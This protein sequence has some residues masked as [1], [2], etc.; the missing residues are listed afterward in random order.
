MAMALLLAGCDAKDAA[1]MW[2][3]AADELRGAPSA[4]ALQ[5]SAH[6][7]DGGVAFDYPTVLRERVD[8]DDDGD[9]SWNFEYGMYTLEV[10]HSRGEMAAADYLGALGELFAGGERLDA[11]PLAQGEPRELC[12]A[13]RTPARV[14]LKLMGDWSEMQAFDL[15][16]PKGESRLLIFDDELVSGAPSAL[17]RATF[18]RVLSTLRC[19]DRS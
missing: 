18:E 9:R 11:E 12:G 7:A 2:N 10:H 4:E 5:K 16:A 14:R 15:P 3:S 19:T 8:I 13:R 1:L 17:G 6:F